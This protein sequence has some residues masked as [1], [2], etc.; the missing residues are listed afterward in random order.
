MRVNLFTVTSKSNL[1]QNLRFSPTKFLLELLTLILSGPCQEPLSALCAFFKEEDDDL[2]SEVEYS[3]SENSC[4]SNN[5]DSTDSD[6]SYPPSVS[7]D[8]DIDDYTYVY[9]AREFL[10][11]YVGKFKRQGL[12][13]LKAGGRVRTKRPKGPWP[14][15]ELEAAGP[16]IGT[17][18]FKC[19][20]L[21][22]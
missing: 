10:T 8:Q 18:F 3:G 2:T 12:A 15:K 21:R 5:D 14:S 6:D 11:F 20:F 22:L 19:S 13:T 7:D 4:S 1:L 17:E 9:K 16:A